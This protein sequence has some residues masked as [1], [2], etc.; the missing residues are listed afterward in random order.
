MFLGCT[1][2]TGFPTNLGS[3]QGAILSPTIFI[4]PIADVGLWTEATVFGYADDTTSTINGT[5]L[6]ELAKKCEAEARKIITY[7]SAN[8][9]AANEDKTH[10]VVIRRGGKQKDLIINVGDKN[11]KASPNEKLLGMW[12]ENNLG[13]NTHISNLENRLKFRLFNLRR[14]AEH[15]PKSLL[16]TIADGIFICLE[17]WATYNTGP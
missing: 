16:K 14:L 3:P 11:F 2:N 17:I 15:I 7:M 6:D 4:I 12:V 8:K 13:W 10:I 5:D 9:L 1:Y